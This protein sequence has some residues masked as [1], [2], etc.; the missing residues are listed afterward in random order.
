MV[1]MLVIVSVCYLIVGLS[2]P[3]IARDIYRD[4]GDKILEVSSLL[5]CWKK[6]KWLL[7]IV[8]LPLLIRDIR[9]LLVEY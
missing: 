3:S 9:S 6:R 2:V 7:P 4:E 8:W 1:E 5:R